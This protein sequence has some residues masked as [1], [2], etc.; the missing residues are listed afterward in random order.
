MMH[1]APRSITTLGAILSFLVTAALTTPATAQDSGDKVSGDKGSGDQA[2]GGNDLRNIRLG[3]PATDLVDAGYADLACATD[4]QK[5]LTT[6]QGWRDCPADASGF[7]AI[8]FG[9]DPATSRE[10]TIVAGHP[11]ILTLLVDDA[12][13]VSGLRIETD[14]KAR[15]YI[16]KKAFLFGTQAKS[17]YGL[18]GW[19]C[20]EAQPD[21][22]E[23]PV[24]G[25]FVRER[26]TKTIS[27]RS[28]V[29]ERSLFRRPEQDIK[30]FVDE[31]RMTI[32]LTKG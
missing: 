9:Y 2:S 21:A 7:H 5:S 8:K 10:G 30:S 17:R 4:P 27:Q 16:R 29:V 22:G 23:Q 6:W 31:T 32:L 28:I 20:T 26:C 1:R 14:P 13:I 12:G 19:S 24:G 3:M 15:L 18:D 11:A 25:V